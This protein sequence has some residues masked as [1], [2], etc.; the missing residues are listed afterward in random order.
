MSGGVI[1]PFVSFSFQ[2]SVGLSG[3][4]H[5]ATDDCAREPSRV[6]NV[7][8]EVKRK[9][10]TELSF[11]AKQFSCLLS[12]GCIED[13][14]HLVGHGFLE[15]LRNLLTLNLFEKADNFGHIDLDPHRFDFR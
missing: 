10:M 11:Q 12:G 15:H 1:L 7:A 14:A 3:Y 8:G 6:I 5:G 13:R 2:K 4:G 9:S